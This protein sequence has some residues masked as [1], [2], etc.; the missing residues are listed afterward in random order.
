LR[1][2]HQSVWCAYAAFMSVLL[3]RYLTISRVHRSGESA[4]VSA[5]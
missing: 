5:R 2:H 4:A 1:L 3:Y